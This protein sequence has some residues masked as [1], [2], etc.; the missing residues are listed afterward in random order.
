MGTEKVLIFG[1]CPCDS[2]IFLE[3]LRQE[4]RLVI[5]ADGGL[6]CARAAGFRPQI[7]VGDGDSGGLPEPDLTC[8]TLPVE[9][10]WT[11]LE[12]AWRWAVERGCRDVVFTAC[13]GGRLD[14]QMAAFCL[15]ETAAELGIRAKILDPCN[16]ITCLLPGQYVL[17]ADGYQFFSLL[18]MDRTLEDLTITGA[19]YP[20]SHAHTR[21]GSSLTVSNEPLDGPV[22][23]TIGTGRCW[24]IR[25]NDAK[26]IK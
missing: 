22:T 1:S 6:H 15:L 21:R 26:S 9:K 3:P 8:V 14:H 4:H 24:L 16:E 19:K 10:D 20:L 17:Q 12:A 18:P 25:S 2:W 5:C 23:L 11:D 13:T 7:Y